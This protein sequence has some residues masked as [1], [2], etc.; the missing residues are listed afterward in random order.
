MSIK[1]M[2]YK[3]DFEKLGEILGDNL[4][5]PNALP[6]KSA[7]VSV[8]VAIKKIYNFHLFFI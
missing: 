5:L 8:I 4:C 6:Q 1:Q 2:K 7:K 3:D